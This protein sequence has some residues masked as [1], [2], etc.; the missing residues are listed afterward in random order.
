M[1]INAPTLASG[2]ENSQ[3]LEVTMEINFTRY[4]FGFKEACNP[5]ASVV[6]WMTN[7]RGLLTVSCYSSWCETHVNQLWNGILKIPKASSCSKR[8]PKR[9]RNDNQIDCFGAMGL[10]VLF[11]SMTEQCF[12]RFFYNMSMA[13]NC[14]ISWWVLHLGKD[15]KGVVKV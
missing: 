4:G 10:Q 7:A 1:E 15:L 14:L 5:A 11:W 8:Y 13:E 2:S 12:V 9:Y 3:M 6:N